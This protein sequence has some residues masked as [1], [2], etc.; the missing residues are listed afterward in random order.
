[1]FTEKEL[2]EIKKDIENQLSPEQEEFNKEY[3]S[4]EELEK[5]IKKKD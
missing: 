3:P 4:W 2:E 1:M 5:T